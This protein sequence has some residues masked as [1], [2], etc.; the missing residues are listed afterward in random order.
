MAVQ[1]YRTASSSNSKIF[2][3]PLLVVQN[4]SALARDSGGLP[5]STSHFGE[6][7]LT[8]YFLLALT[9]SMITLM[10]K[11]FDNEDKTN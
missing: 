10:L 9:N 7:I 2:I 3:L 6:M 5:T 4:L 1:K 8:L 11:Q